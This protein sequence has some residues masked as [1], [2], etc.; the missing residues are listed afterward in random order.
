MKNKYIN[1]LPSRKPK[2]LNV[3]RRVTRNSFF[4]LGSTGSGIITRLAIFPIIAR[5]LG[6]QS[7]GVFT[8][9]LAISMS[10]SLIANF[11]AERILSREMATT[12]KN[13]DTFFSTSIVIALLL[14][15]VLITG[16]IIL[17]HVFSPWERQINLAL[18]LGISEQLFF[19][20]G[21]MYLAVIRGFEKMEF[22]TLASFV[23]QLSLF[24]LVLGA[25]FFDE[26]I[27]GIFWAR[28]AASIF[29]LIIS[30]VL[31]YTLFL[32]PKLDFKL[33][34]AKY[35]ITESFPVMA[36]SMLLGLI[37]KVDV[38]L[39]GW[40]KTAEEV[41]LYEGPHRLLSLTQ[42][43]A[44]TI[45]F[46]VLPILSRAF[47]E[48][49]KNLLKA[50]YDTTYKFLLVSGVLGTIVVFTAGKPLIFLLLGNEFDDAVISM[51]IMA[52]IVVFLFLI[53]L[54]TSLLLAV[55]QQRLS[56]FAVGISLVVNIVL[57]VLLI[58]SYSYIGAS[59]ATLLSYFIFM[60]MTASF[61][62][63]QGI[64]YNHLKTALKLLSICLILLCITLLNF[65]ND[66]ITLLARCI[67]G[68]TGYLLLLILFRVF[69]P[70]ELQRIKDTLVL[71]KAGKKKS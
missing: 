51:Q 39:L 34:Y 28:F 36:F 13:P 31:T 43:L 65:S 20:I 33:N 56:T 66:F 35:I 53:Q 54:Q 23:H 26:G 14:S 58:P 45:T 44:T 70:V 25:V 63:K 46:S 61:I 55:K 52:P 71:K 48:G 3:A 11:G 69:S 42:V 8:L 32:A 6:L 40:L 4:L 7:F 2:V 38:F 30:M 37:F 22:D 41:A 19:C 21:Q 64:H 12:Q 10:F 24:G 1:V 27:V 60:Y 57:D 67:A 59:I 29:F 49:K 68:G 62:K 47:A 18:M 50:Y 5:Y 16:S 9:I 17:I 15:L